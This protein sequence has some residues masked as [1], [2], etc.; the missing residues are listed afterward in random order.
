MDA[1]D[2][3]ED[4]PTRSDQRRET[5]LILR[6]LTPAVF[7]ALFHNRNSSRERP[8]RAQACSTVSSPTSTAAKISAFLPT[9]QRLGRVDGRSFGGRTSPLGPSGNRTEGNGF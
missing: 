9:T 5:R 6:P 3:G 7:T 4:S 8:Y 1:H 2:A